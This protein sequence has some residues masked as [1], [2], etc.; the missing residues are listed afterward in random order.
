MSKDFTLSYHTYVS[1]DLEPV[2]CAYSTRMSAS[3]IEVSEQAHVIFDYHCVDEE[4][5]DYHI[6][7]EPHLHWRLE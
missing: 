1:I 5:T 4:L 6:T 3:E 7:A 2:R